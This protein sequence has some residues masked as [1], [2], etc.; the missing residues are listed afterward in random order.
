[1]VVGFRHKGLRQYCGKGS[2]RG[3]QHDHAKKLRRILAALDAASRPA[4]LNLP[5]YDLHPLKGDRAGTWSISVS[6]NWRVTFRFDGN[7]VTDVDY[8]DYH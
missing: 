8:E 3:I 1:V 4:D 7:D 2:T 5:G 6:G